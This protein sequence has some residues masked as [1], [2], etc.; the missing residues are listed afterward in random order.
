M[1]PDGVL[2]LF[3]EPGTLAAHASGVGLEADA[4]VLDQVA[5]VETALATLHLPSRRCGV[6]TLRDVAAV[7]RDAREGCVFNLVESLAGSV[8]D[9]AFVPAFCRAHGKAVTGND[10]ASQIVGLDKALA[11]AALRAAGIVTPEGMVVRPGDPPGALPP[12]PAIV[13]PLLSD[14]SEGIDADAI[15]TP[16]QGEAT[17]RARIAR[18]HAR[19]GQPALVERYIDGREV[20]ASV[21]ERDGAPWVLPLA[22]IEFV[23]Y[24]DDRPR[25]VDYAAKWL[26]DS[27][28]YG[29]TPRRVP[30]DLPEAAA[31]RIRAAARAAW[32]AVGAAGYARV[33]FRLDADL[34]PYVLEINP[35][36]DISP[37]AGLAAA[38]AAA[39]LTYAAFVRLVIDSARRRHAADAAPA[40]PADATP[41]RRAA[42]PPL[43]P[44]AIVRRSVPADRDAVMALL[45]A[46][47]FFHPHELTIA[48]EVLDEALRDGPAGHYQSYVAAAGA[49]MLGW[50]CF[51]PTPCTDGTWDIY[52][53]GVHPAAQ[54]R[55]IGRLLMSFCEDRLRERGA[56][57]AVAETAGR[58]QYAGTRAFYEACGYTAVSTIPDFYAPGDARIT[59]T[60]A[61]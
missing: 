55:G 14:A 9:V 38:V 46:T 61:L 22:E 47:A 51:G 33:D 31:E 10:A 49:D 32:E 37:D 11:K 34:N 5:A 30:A 59:L 6:R 1:I 24:G 52:W 43:P 18:I 56:R 58:E 41:P 54:G 28:A 19:F 17:V 35:N 23:G 44:S 2:I 27:Y 57:L 25:I 42:R 21:L 20:N 7:L 26:P 40:A 39:G 45:E 60:K 16:D 3:N 15:V 29:H 8:Q 36:P 48:A 4:G 12:L 13:K 50:V 53:M